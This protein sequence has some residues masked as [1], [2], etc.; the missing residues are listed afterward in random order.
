MSGVHRPS[1]RRVRAL[2]IRFAQFC[3]QFCK[4]PHP[5]SCRSR[6]RR[7]P[8]QCSLC[9]DIDSVTAMDGSGRSLALTASELEFCVSEALNGH[10][11]A[12]LGA[13]PYYSAGKPHQQH[14]RRSPCAFLRH[15]QAEWELVKIY[16][17]FA[18]PKPWV[19]I[20]VRTGSKAGARQRAPAI[21]GQEPRHRCRRP[22]H[23]DFS[24]VPTAFFTM[25]GT[26]GPFQLN[27]PTHVPLWLAVR[28]KQDQ[29]C[30]VAPPDWL[31]YGEHT[32]VRVAPPRLRLGLCVL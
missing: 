25:Q 9:T 24:T 28:L 17:K 22:D 23:N 27:V 13:C 6:V 31:T 1:P 20:S 12:H 10:L 18:D 5:I 29:K 26:F 32:S 16:P 14:H 15:S 11:W 7:R 30:R 21:I 19:F 4:A 3:M 8:Y 2:G